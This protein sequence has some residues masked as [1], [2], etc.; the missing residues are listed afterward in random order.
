MILEKI[1]IQYKN[2]VLNTI[3][4]PDLSDKNLLLS[5]WANFHA[6]T[7][8]QSL[9]KGMS[10]AVLELNHHLKVG[11]NKKIIKLKSYSWIRKEL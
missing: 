1:E 6:P 3:A 10:R 2:Y 5:T 11:V 7:I 8:S 9:E 4:S